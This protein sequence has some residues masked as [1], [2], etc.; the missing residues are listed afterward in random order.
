MSGGRQACLVGVGETAYT[1]RGGSGVREYRLAVEAI[2]LALADAG[3]DPADVD[4]LAPYA[5]ERSQP[6]T[7]SA[8]LGLRELRFA[9]TTAM[10]GGGGA[11]AAVLEAALAIEA[12]QADVVVV[13]RSLCQG[14]FARIGGIQAQPTVAAPPQLHEAGLE[15]E[16]LQS[17]TAPFGVLGPA[18]I[19]ALPMRRHMAMY[20][21]TSEQLG[22]VAVA[23]RA[24][25]ARN[26]HAVMSNRPLTLADHQASRMVADPYRLFDCCLETDG[27]CAVVVTT[28]ERA[29]DLPHRPVA[30]LSGAEGSDR[31]RLGGALA[32]AGSSAA[33]YPGG[34]AGPVAAR[35][36]GRA[37]LQPGDVD[38][39]QLYDN[40][41]GQVLFGLEDF[42]F[43]ERGESGPFVE[44]GA[45]S[46]PNGALPTNTAGGNLS[47]AYMQGLNHVIEGVRQ[48]RGD[49]TSQVAGA[50]VCL[51]TSSP[52]IPTS[53][54]LLGRP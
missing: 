45:L 11:C 27:A 43:C 18:V 47:E 7:L 41:S 32:N 12:G 35:L 34:G 26:P 29:A 53:A 52:G 2:L 54:L 39:A 1:K 51:V 19:F 15:T 38:V 21:T 42:G 20:G 50:E 6:W 30:V 14:Q 16:A 36:F 31:A 33:D 5:D 48:I 17:F 37:G 10:P 3:I 44:T 28:A 9:T 25:A 23:Q 49:A 24:H 46:W 40:F 13:Y 8:D 4:G 22:T